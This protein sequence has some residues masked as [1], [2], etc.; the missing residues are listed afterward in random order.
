MLSTTTNKLTHKQHQLTQT[1]DTTLDCERL[2]GRHT[3]DG[4]RVPFRNVR[5]SRVHVI[6]KKFHVRYFRC[7]PILNVTI[8]TNNMIVRRAATC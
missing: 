1:K 6:K 4:P 7:V 2:T 3:G 5:V 8:R